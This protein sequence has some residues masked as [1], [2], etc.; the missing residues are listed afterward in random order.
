MKLYIDF[1][2]TLFDNSKLY[3]QFISI[4]KKYNISEKDI[5]K[6][7]KEKYQKHK[8][9]DILAKDLIDKYNLDISILNEIDNLY[10]KDLIY[11]DVIPFLEKYYQNHELILLT[12]GNISYQQKKINSVDIDKYFKNIIITDKDKSK[13][14]IN[15]PEGLFID[16]NPNELTKFYNS[17][18]RHLI[19]IKRETDKY[20]KYNLNI[21]N[22]PEFKNFNEIDKYITKI[23]DIN[24]E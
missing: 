3:K 10:S 22:I 6:L 14:N 21:E 19:R 4:F 7:M 23:G 2:G 18:A 13:L 1:D 8:C 17:K 9:F 16:N 5:N 11:S 24:Y 15:Y 12:I 20:S